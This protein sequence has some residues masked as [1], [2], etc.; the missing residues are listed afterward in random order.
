MNRHLKL[1]FFLAPFL[2][3][4][5]YLLSDFYLEDQANKLR[6]FQMQPFGHCDVY[7][8]K[9]ILQSGEFKI[10]V[11]HEN[12]ISTV[13]TTYPL[14]TAT[15]FLVDDENKATAYQLGMKNS[16]YYWKR[17]TPLGN[18]IAKKG[19]KY[20]LRFIGEIKGGKYIAEFYTQ[21]VN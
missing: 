14:D 18:Y 15:L 20:K 13:N 2:I 4:G 16:P 9:C 21:T 3:L 5:G 7:N 1:A 17:E 19:D 11:M 8:Q 6:L 10:N 12:G